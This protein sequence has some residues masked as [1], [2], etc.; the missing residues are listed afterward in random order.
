MIGVIRSELVRLWRP[1]LL[2]GWFGLTA[3][4]AVMVNTI[5]FSSAETLGTGPQVGPGATSRGTR[6]GGRHRRRPVERIHAVRRDH[7]G[8]LGGERGE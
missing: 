5:M 4:F 7:V 6:T 8:V 2:A 3:L 1:K